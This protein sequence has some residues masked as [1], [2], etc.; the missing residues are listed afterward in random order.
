MKTQSVFPGL[1]ALALLL[2]T[3]AQV[4]AW[5][6]AHFGY[7]HVGPN[8]V[9]HYGATSAFAYGPGGS[10]HP[11]SSSAFGYSGAYTAGYHSYAPTNSGGYAAGGYHYGTFGGGY[12]AG[13]YRGF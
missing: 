2:L 6:A 11:A 9:Q 3:S 4:Q 5:G 12:S 7:T 10:Y 1:A 8:G 13:V